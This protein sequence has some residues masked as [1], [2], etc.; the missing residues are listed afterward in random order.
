MASSGE[1]RRS[2]AAHGRGDG[3][4][5]ASTRC[6]T[7]TATSWCSWPGP[8]TS[9]GSSRCSEVRAARRRRRPPAVRRALAPG[10]GPGAGPL[11]GRVAAGSSSPPTSP[12]P[13]SRSRASG[14]SSTA[15][16]SAVLTTTRAAASRDCAPGPTPRPRPTSAPGVPGRTEPGVAYRLWSK[17]EQATRRP[18]ADPEIDSVDLAGLALELA[19]WGT[20]A[21]DLTF[22]DPPPAGAR[23]CPDPAPRPRRARRRRPRHRRRTVHGRAPRAS[24]PGPHGHR[25]RR[26]ASAPPPAR[27]PPCSRSATCC[28]AVPTS[29][30]PTCRPTPTH[31]RP[32]HD[33]LG[34]HAALHLVRRRAAELARRA[35]RTGHRSILGTRPD[36][37]G[38]VLALAYPDR[39]AQARGDGRF[40]M[41]H[42]AGAWLPR[43]MR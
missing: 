8:P 20:S 34:R 15:A 32:E 22:L 18:H 10:A 24:A 33:Q 39:V 7:T 30:R 25:R 6:S 43:A 40:R 36:R 21:D 17:M 37:G 4:G 13:A 38:R 2:T 26:P 23:R 14:W 16:R 12:R 42:G 28:A 5:G 11:T 27:S 35:Q 29:C 41:R 3:G 1:P 9:V 19:V 31:R